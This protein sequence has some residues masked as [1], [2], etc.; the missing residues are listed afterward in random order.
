MVEVGTGVE[1]ELN[2][3]KEKLDQALYLLQRDGYNVYKGDFSKLNSFFEKIK[4]TVKIGDLDKYGQSWCRSTCI[5][6]TKGIWKN[7]GSLGTTQLNM[8]MENRRLIFLIRTLMTVFRLQSYYS[9]G[10]V[11]ELEAGSKEEIIS[12]LRFSLFLIRLPMMLGRRLLDYE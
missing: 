9:T 3:S 8:K 1:R 2:I 5:C 10:M 7:S 4:E 12:I 6:H 11:L